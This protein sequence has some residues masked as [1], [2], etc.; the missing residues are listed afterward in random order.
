[1]PLSRIWLTPD[2]G[3]GFHYFQ[4]TTSQYDGLPHTHG[5]YC[6]VACLSGQIGFRYRSAEQVARAGEVVIVNPGQFHQCFFGIGGL[7]SSG[8]TVI[9]RPS[10][11]RSL[12][13]AM[14][15]PFHSSDIRF[16]GTH[17]DEDVLEL[18]DKLINEFE[19]QRQGRATMLELLLRQIVICLLRSWP[20][21]LMQPGELDL[22]PQLPWVQMHRA[23]EFMNSHGKNSFRLTD[24]CADVG[25]SPS[26]FISLFKNSSGISPHFYYNSLLVLKARRLLQIERASTKEAAYALGFKNV[27]HFCALFHQLTGVTPRADHVDH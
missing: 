12:V 23:T 7:S 17:R 11:L 22:P 25:V 26:R 8:L 15:L 5:E 21:T 27:S 9:V 4:Y 10:V 13:Q 19:A 2:L 16:M 18:I 24:L 3:L 20:L 6:L 1:M 14:S